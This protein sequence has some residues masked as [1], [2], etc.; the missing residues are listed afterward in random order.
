MKW[1]QDSLLIKMSTRIKGKRHDV[2]LRHDFSVYGQVGR[3]LLRLVK[4]RKLLKIGQGIYV[5]ATLTPLF[6]RPFL[7]RSLNSLVLE[8]MKKLGIQ[9]GLTAMEIKYNE[10][11]PLKFQQV[12]L[13]VCANVFAAVLDSVGRA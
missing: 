9:T 1:V 7:P 8:A 10:T 4:Q 6:A 5:H 11:K 12:A 2:I 13:S 3:C